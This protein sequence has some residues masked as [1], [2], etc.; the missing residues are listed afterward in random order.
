[1]YDRGDYAQAR[2]HFQ[3]GFALACQIGDPELKSRML[4]NL[5]LVAVALG[6]YSELALARQN[7]LI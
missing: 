1:M 4:G 6:N 7:S 2:E 5:G 3:E